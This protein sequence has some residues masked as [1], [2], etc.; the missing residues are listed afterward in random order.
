MISPSHP[1]APAA[2]STETADTEDAATLRLL[3]GLLLPDFGR[4]WGGPPW[5]AGD[6][7]PNPRP[8]R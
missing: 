5:W 6:T 2:A 1:P 4:W 7:P 3:A 8:C